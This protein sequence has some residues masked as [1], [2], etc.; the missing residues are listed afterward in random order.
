MSC[1][2]L[3]LGRQALQLNIIGLRDDYICYKTIFIY[4]LKWRHNR[5]GY[6]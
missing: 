2:P 4:F 1:E 6:G 3:I 5:A